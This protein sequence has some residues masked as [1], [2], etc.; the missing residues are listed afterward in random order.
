[1]T[2]F[3]PKETEATGEAHLTFFRL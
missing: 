1:M 2:L 3:S